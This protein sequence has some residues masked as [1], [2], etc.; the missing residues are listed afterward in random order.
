MPE[1]VGD[2]EVT[3]DT[4]LGGRV[5]LR[6]PR[7]GNR[8]GTDAVLL[9][10]LAES[11]PG[12][13]V[14]DLGSASGA[15]GLMVAARTDLADLSLLDRDANLVSLAAENIALNGLQDRARAIRLDA[16]DASSWPAGDDLV[17]PADL[18]VTNPP[19]FDGG[20]R[21]SPH[22]GRRDAHVL[23]GGDL[24]AWVSAGSRLLKPRGRICIIHRAEALH[25]V[26]NAIGAAFGDVVARP[27]QP[28]HGED[29]TR[30][31]VSARKSGR[32]PFRLA[33]PLV[34]HEEDGAFTPDA[35]RFHGLAATSQFAGFG[36]PGR[37]PSP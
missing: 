5:R 26:L 13:R 20:G 22:R 10:G 14:I 25:A 18:L 28:R 36:Q 15:V 24:A 21:V 7:R 33:A 23:S 1:T 29:A 6:Q 2:A 4:L 30:V 16:F 27:I 3:D 32:G 19:W 12:D 35:A 31:V 34:L 11:R 17:R 37:T 9:A 8:A